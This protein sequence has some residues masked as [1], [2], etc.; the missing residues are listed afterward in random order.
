MPAVN[1][2]FAQGLVL[3]REAGRHGYRRQS[4]VPPQ[5]TLLLTCRQ[6]ATF[7][8]ASQPPCLPPVS[9]LPCHQRPTSLAVGQPAFS[10]PAAGGDPLKGGGHSLRQPPLPLELLRI[11]GLRSLYQAIF[12]M[13]LAGVLANQALR[14]ACLQQQQAGILAYPGR[15][16]LVA[17]R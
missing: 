13:P 4:T 16:W 3:P 5:A 15:G 8:A 7:L 12:S 11:A 1:D 14:R 10:P 17:A 9:H 2:A 6:P